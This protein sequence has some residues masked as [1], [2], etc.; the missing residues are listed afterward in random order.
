LQRSYSLFFIKE[1]REDSL[2]HVVALGSGILN[3]MIR[4]NNVPQGKRDEEIG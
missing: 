3:G 4:C 1:T 2:D